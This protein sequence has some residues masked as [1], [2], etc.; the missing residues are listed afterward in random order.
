MELEVCPSSSTNVH[1]CKKIEF[2]NVIFCEKRSQNY[3]KMQIGVWRR[4]KHHNSLD[5]SLEFQKQSNTTVQCCWVSDVK[6]KALTQTKS[7]LV[8][9]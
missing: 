7:L 1:F 5:K 3:P 9:S 4:C 2:S 8:A 6:T